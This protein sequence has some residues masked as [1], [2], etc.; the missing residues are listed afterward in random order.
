MADLEEQFE[1]RRAFFR[2]FADGTIEL[3]S[4]LSL[5]AAADQVAAGLLSLAEF[6]STNDRASER[7]KRRAHGREI[8][9]RSFGKLAPARETKGA[10]AR[11]CGRAIVARIKGRNA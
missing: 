6:A 10:A 8:A 11:E 9:L 2:A 1:R 7:A 3:P 5:D 4:H